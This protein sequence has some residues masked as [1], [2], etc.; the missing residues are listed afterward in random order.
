MI[1]VPVASPWRCVQT[2]RPLPPKRHMLSGPDWRVARAAIPAATA[3][4]VP[5]PV[6]KPTVVACQARRSTAFSDTPM[7]QARP[8]P[9]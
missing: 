9:S 3:A 6:L 7:A 1:N 5:P 2:V 8:W 4:H